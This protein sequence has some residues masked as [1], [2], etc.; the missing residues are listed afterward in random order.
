MSD[1][2]QVTYE[3]LHGVGA[4]NSHDWKRYCT[5]P[6]TGFLERARHGKNS[7]SQIALDEMYEKLHVPA[8]N[9]IELQFF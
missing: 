8:F 9:R 2:R 6:E 3:H 1:V 5:D 7:S 4:N